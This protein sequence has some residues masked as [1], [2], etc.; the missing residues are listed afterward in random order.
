M[1]FVKTPMRVSFC[2][3]GSDIPIF[4]ERHGGIVISAGLSRYIYTIVNPRFADTQVMCKYMS[5]TECVEELSQLHHPILRNV[6]EYFGINGV[7]IIVCSDIPAGTGLGSSSSFTVGLINAL[8]E[9]TQKKASPEYLAQEACKIE[10]DLMKYPMGKQDQYAAAFGGLNV[11]RFEKDGKVSVEAI[12]MSKNAISY[13]EENLL[14]FYT[15]NVRAS[16]DILSQQIENIKNDTKKEQAQ[17]KICEYAEE[18]YKIFINEKIDEV[19]PLLHACWEQKR[20]LAEEISNTFIDQLYQRALSAGASGGKLL[21]A[22]SSGFLLF[23]VTPQYHNSVKN[24]LKDLK[25]MK[26]GFSPHGSKLIYN[27]NS[28]TLSSL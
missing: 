10:I 20:T 9:Y 16:S 28:P 2:G 22:G 23:Y 26:F 15:G 25:Y 11:F 1:I 6:L 8:C 14:M 19:G 3:G 17:K 7:E 18:L 21:G 4:Y 13:L 12:C 24:A 5:T 27:S